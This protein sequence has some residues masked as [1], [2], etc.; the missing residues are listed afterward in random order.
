M[1][2]DQ[3]LET[4]LS[5]YAANT[6]AAEAACEQIYP[7]LKNWGGDRLLRADYS[8]SYAK[9]TAI[10]LGS[11]ADIFLSL[12]SNVPNSLANSYNTLFKA[13]ELAGYKP[14]KQNVSIGVTVNGCSIDLV[15]ARRLSQHGNE[16][17]LFKSKTNSWT[18]TN[19]I[20]HINYVKNSGRTEEIKILKIWRSLHNLVWPSLYLEMAV[21]EAL[22]NKNHSNLAQ[23]V[24]TALEYLRDN[25]KTKK[26]VDIANSRNIISLDCNIIEKNNI[27]KKARES[28]SQTNWNKVVW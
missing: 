6:A 12:S 10:S 24:L 20:G 9:G 7:V 1:S 3:Y 17:N 26:F 4:I 14:R 22:Y 2:G 15:P 16:H 27:A 13:V 28:M 5:K 21:I 23:N 19:V 18:K 8:G 25:I 11:D